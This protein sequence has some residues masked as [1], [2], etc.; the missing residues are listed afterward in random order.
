MVLN[1][2]DFSWA[3]LSAVD[4]GDTTRGTGVSWVSATVAVRGGSTSLTAISRA[5]VSMTGA[6]W[7]TSSAVT[8]SSIGEV[9]TD[10]SDIMRADTDG[11]STSCAMGTHRGDDLITLATSTDDTLATGGPTCIGSLHVS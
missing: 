6:T 1:Y 5:D 4:D 11:I 7:D 2:W 8:V 3:S 10:I 9:H